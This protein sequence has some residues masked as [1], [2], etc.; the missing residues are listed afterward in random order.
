MVRV[1]GAALTVDRVTVV[2]DSL[3]E[4]AMASRLRV[5]PL[6]VMV[7]SSSSSSN[8]N[9]F[10]SSSRSSS[11]AMTA[12]DSRDPNP[13]L[14][15]VTSRM[16]SSDLM[17]SSQEEVLAEERTGGLKVDMRDAMKVIAGGLATK[18]ART[19]RRVSGAEV[20]GVMTAEA[21]TEVAAV[22]HPPVWVVVTVV[23]TKITVEPETTVRRMMEVS[24]ENTSP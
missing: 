16:D 6:V 12:T 24:A 10:R 5:T 1:M 22:A 23:A 18:V 14:V 13:H 3:V 8:S 15:M 19:G 2:M 20:V 7:S 11:R 21:M 17:D 4:R 9:P